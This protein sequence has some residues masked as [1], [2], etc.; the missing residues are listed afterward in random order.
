MTSEEKAEKQAEA[1]KEAKEVIKKLNNGENFSELAKK[2]S[3][4]DNT[5]S[6]GGDI[7]WFNT[8]EMDANFEKAAFALKKD[9]YTKTPVESTYGYHIIYKVDE[10]AKPKLTDVKDKIKSTLVTNKLSADKTLYYSTLEKI[11]KSYELDIVDSELKNIYN[12]Y[13]DTLIKNAKS[14]TNTSK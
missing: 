5:A 8:G 4:D 3:D 10:K 1:L 6:K 13:E 14:S 7:G 12:D 11:R 2:Y 9:E